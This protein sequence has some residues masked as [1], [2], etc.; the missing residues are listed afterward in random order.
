MPQVTTDQSM[1]ASHVSLADFMDS[2]MLEDSKPDRIMRFDGIDS[3]RDSDGKE[4][5]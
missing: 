4:E 2:G 1:R 5:Q 3:C